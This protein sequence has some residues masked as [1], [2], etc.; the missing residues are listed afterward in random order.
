MWKKVLF[1]LAIVMTAPLA[2]VNCTASGEV[3]PDEGTQ[4]DS[5]TSGTSSTSPSKTRQE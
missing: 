1:T 2:L 5:S 4:S 3:H